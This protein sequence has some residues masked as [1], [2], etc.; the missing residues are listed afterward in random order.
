[1]VGCCKH[2]VKFVSQLNNYYLY[3]ENMLI[4]KDKGRNM[5]QQPTLGPL[6]N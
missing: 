4:M 2:G 6:F 3:M 5:F 1:M